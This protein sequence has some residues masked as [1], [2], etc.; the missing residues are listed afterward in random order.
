MSEELNHAGP[1]LAIGSGQL[2]SGFSFL[3]RLRPEQGLAKPRLEQRSVPR[4]QHQRIARGGDLEDDER[5]AVG[6]VQHGHRGVEFAHLPYGRG[7]A[8]AAR[9]RDTRKIDTR[10]G[11][12]R[13]HPVSP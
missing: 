5:R 7:L 1:T 12:G 9:A 13:F 8:E 3:G 4:W 10:A 6:R 11:V 2:S